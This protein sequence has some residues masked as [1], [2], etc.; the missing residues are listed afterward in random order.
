METLIDDINSLSNQ[1]ILKN[2]EINLEKD[3][4]TKQ[5]LNKELN[6]LKLKKE[7]AVIKKKI[8]QLEIR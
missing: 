7:I 3:S 2:N 4:I 8:R 6:V 5:K 1:I